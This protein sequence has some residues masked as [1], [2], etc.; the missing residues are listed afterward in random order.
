MANT[1]MSA[2]N[3]F[4]EG[5]VM[6]LSPTNS[7]A[8]SLSSALNATLITYNGNE[9]SLQNDM[10]NARV[11]TAFLPEGYVPV[12]TCEFGDIIYVVS[13]NPLINKSQIGCFP[14][15]ERNI[16]TEESGDPDQVLSWKDFQKDD[17]ETSGLLK[18]TSVKK[19]LY[20]SKNMNSG[21]QYIVYS[22]NL[23]G[24]HLSDYGN[25]SHKHEEFPKLVK[26]HV[27]SI[28]ESGKIV[29]LDSTTKWYDNNY[30]INNNVK[31]Q[32]DG[33]LLLDSYRTM[34][35]SAYSVF[36]SK[37]SGKLALLIELEKITGFSC[38]WEPFIEKVEKVEK[39]E[40]SEAQE[41][42]WYSIYWNFNWTTNNNNINPNGAVLM[43]SEWSG[44]DYN[45][46]GQYQEWS[47]TNGKYELKEWQNAGNP[48]KIYTEESE[49]ESKK[50]SITFTRRY[51][52]ESNDISYSQFIQKYSKGE[53]C[54]DYQEY[55]KEMI[56]I[57]S[58]PTTPFKLNIDK[59][60]ETGL[61]K[62]G[63]YYV[64]C[65]KYLDKDI[66]EY[67]KGYYTIDNEGKLTSITAIELND[68]FVNNYFHYPIIKKFAN[69]KI[70]TKQIFKEGKD[71]V[72]KTPYINNLVYHYKIAPTMPYGILEELAQEGYIDFSKIGT[73]SIE[74]NTWKY[75]NYENTSTLTWGMEAYT[76]PGKG[77]SEVVFEFYDNQGFAAAYHNKGKRSYNGVFTE[78]ITFNEDGSNYKLNSVPAFPEDPKNPEK[79]HKGI[80][81]VAE[82]DSDG[83]YYIPIGKVYEGDD[84]KLMLTK[85]KKPC[86]EGTTYWDNDAGK[87][88]SNFLYLV[89]IITK[90]CNKNNLGEY[91]EPTEPTESV[92]YEYRWFWTNTMFNEYYYQVNDF[93]DL[94]FNLSFDINAIYDQKNPDI[95]GETL[96][97]NGTPS[98]DNTE[99]NNNEYT[100]LKAN[101]TQI[102]QGKDTISDTNGNI[103]CKIQI[104]LQNDYNTFNIGVDNTSDN[105]LNKIII[106][107][108]LGKAY[109][110]NSECS[111]ISTEEL[112]Y[113]F[114]GIY[115]TNASNE[116]LNESN[117]KIEGLGKKLHEL[118]KI[119]GGK[120][121]EEI[122]SYKTSYQNYKNILALTYPTSYE[123]NSKEITYPNQFEEDL[124]TKECEWVENKINDVEYHYGDKSIDFTLS[125]IIYSKFYG[126]QNNMITNAKLVKPLL[127]SQEDLEKY[128]MSFY[129]NHFYFN[130]FGGIMLGNDSGGS[131]RCSFRVHKQEN[132]SS[133]YYRLTNLGGNLGAAADDKDYWNGG[134]LFTHLQNTGDA[135]SMYEVFPG[136]TPFVLV[137]E[138][139]KWGN[140]YAVLKGNLKDDNHIEENNPANGSSTLYGKYFGSFPG[141]NIGSG[142]HESNLKP[143]NNK[144]GFVVLTMSDKENQLH[145]LNTFIPVKFSN[146]SYL[147]QEVRT[148]ASDI[149]SGTTIG[150]LIA[151]VLMNLYYNTD[152]SKEITYQGQSNFVYLNKHN[153]TF[154]KDIIHEVKVD[155]NVEES[156]LITIRRIKYDDY[157]DK[158]IKRSK[159]S[160]EET[161][162]LLN[163]PNVKVKINSLLKNCPIQLQYNYITPL[164]E[165][166]SSPNQVIKCS[167]GS[168]IYSN[169]N[170]TPNKFYFQ[171]LND[172]NIF[173][174]LE[175]NLEYKYKLYKNFSENSYGQF[176][177]IK[178][179]TTLSD[180][181]FAD[182]FIIN[183]GELR[184]KETN[185][186]AANDSNSLSINGAESDWAPLWPVYKKEGLIP[187]AKLS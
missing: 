49:E 71:F 179:D 129:G 33:K 91:L 116:E 1:R 149:I 164:Q 40:T 186:T 60:E 167:D 178:T 103:S 77:I 44:V 65:Y 73:K 9:M 24:L 159:I 117:G 161:S 172:P 174:R 6:D 22:E 3:G 100:Q 64:N 42:T 90:Y 163:S 139:D 105:P 160:N 153:Y 28:E 95:F 21:D 84:G 166:H 69:F 47:D 93:K 101:V 79:Y 158:V 46:K 10:G 12:G 80:E 147:S 26:I 181:T 107:T 74:L 157:I 30:Y 121:G 143:I 17:V 57:I 52:P 34:V 130:Q 126:I 48:P 145:F 38:S 132:S 31:Q 56:D 39:V 162:A 23:D 106:K 113:I 58:S 148:I 36:S 7:S 85:E 14:S 92:K 152:E 124:I 32:S 156:T 72:S 135:G 108:Y 11:E 173:N 110:E 102:N 18:T 146:G 131:N 128:N 114:P 115:P 55:V 138:G 96:L 68:D 127:Y 111:A 94:Q 182:A 183:N 61:P 45:H 51:A 35:S 67:T 83:N 75:Y 125:G 63:Y 133:N 136:I 123:K 70:P 41:N 98:K 150:D 4:Q 29:Y 19:I 171:D 141:Y 50:T 109:L 137:S 185:A 82:K 25:T 89:K 175:Y 2:K 13:Y 43:T 16:S 142:I 118:L 87:L 66:N 165:I 187:I 112:G 27:V 177:G 59:Y 88:Y 86:D 5:L 155:D 119:N 176:I 15:P 78:Y 168:E 20:S 144:N 37:V 54:Y 99:V 81:Y 151:S 134:N 120:E 180:N 140:N 154:T 184:C 76:E 53:T 8:N 169:M 62:S 104:G 170:F 97:Y 122:N